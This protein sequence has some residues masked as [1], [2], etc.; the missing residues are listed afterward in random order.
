MGTNTPTSG[1]CVEPIAEP[2]TFWQTIAPSAF[3]IKVIVW[4]GC[5]PLTVCVKPVVPD[6]GVTNVVP[7]SMDTW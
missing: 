6:D 2:V 1:Y 4:L 7:L 3:T 5:K